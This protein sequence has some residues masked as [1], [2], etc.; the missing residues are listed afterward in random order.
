MSP[1]DY[2]EEYHGFRVVMPDLLTSSMILRYQSKS[3]PKQRQE[4]EAVGSALIQKFKIK[5]A[6]V[7]SM[8]R[9]FYLQGHASISPGEVFYREGLKRAYD[10]RGTPEE[11]RDAVRLAVAAG[12]CDANSA[13]AYV[14][15]WFGLDCNTLV[16]N[17]MGLSSGTAIFA[18]VLGYGTAPLAGGTPADE[19]TRGF[20]PFPAA[21]TLQSVGEGSVLVTYSPNR[22]EN[23]NSPDKYNMRFWEHIALIQSFNLIGEEGAD[24]AKGVVSIV[25]WGQAGGPA[26]HIK[27]SAPCEL[28]RG[29]FVKERPGQMFWAIKSGESYRLILNM[30]NAIASGERRKYGVPSN[31]S[32]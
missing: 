20:L 26:E 19:A 12:R 5:A 13:P 16:G 18:Y 31:A 2:V 9:E 14:T 29:K 11:I 25:E 23:P 3:D 15:K 28:V 30:P 22:P 4:F 10:C 1:I 27:M 21:P 6:S 24:S 7:Y 17:W 32:L 8:P